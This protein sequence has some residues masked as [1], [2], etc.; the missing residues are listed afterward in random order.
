M[1]SNAAS[2]I[3]ADAEFA[4]RLQE[5][6]LQFMMG[7]A[8]LPDRRRSPYFLSSTTPPAR[9]SPSAAAGAAA[10]ARNFIRHNSNAGGVPDRTPAPY[11]HTP[12]RE[13]GPDIRQ[14]QHQHQQQHQQHH[15]HHQQHHQ[16]HQ[17]AQRPT[18][19]TTTHFHFESHDGSVMDAFDHLHMMFPGF[20]SIRPHSMHPSARRSRRT[21]FGGGMHATT[22]TTTGGGSG[23]GGGTVDAMAEMS[24]LVGEIPS[25]FNDDAFTQVFPGAATAAGGGG[26]TSFFATGGELPTFFRNILEHH[27]NTYEEFLEMIER[28]GNVNRGATDEEVSHIQT[29]KYVPKPRAASSSA[30]GRAAGTDEAEKCVICLG[31]YERDDVIKR[32]PCG[33]IF[34]SECVDRWLKVN[35]TCPSCKRSIRESDG[36]DNQN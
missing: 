11:A 30:A 34:H 7:P 9:N 28:R 10:N 8:Y 24:R 26:G 35:R 4:R 17:R 14:H 5:E 33:H 32:L 27:P 18:T 36:P 1:S 6:E 31:E 19:T 2:Q 13:E 21:P 22:T 12:A 3:E 25:F 23:G 16:H 29:E 15:Q 20:P